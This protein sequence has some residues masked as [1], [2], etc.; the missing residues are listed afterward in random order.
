[1]AHSEHRPGERIAA[2]SS[3]T[4]AHI[5]RTCERSRPRYQ[6]LTPVTLRRAYQGEAER[7]SG[8]RRTATS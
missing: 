4:P 7:H 1:V 6:P 2:F 8:A 3:S 5:R